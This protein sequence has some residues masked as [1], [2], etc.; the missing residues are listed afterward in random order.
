MKSEQREIFLRAVK[1]DSAAIKLYK[2]RSFI[3]QNPGEA[4]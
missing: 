1:D 4:A 2:Y 3:Q